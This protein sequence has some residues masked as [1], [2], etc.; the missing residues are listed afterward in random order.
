MM[1]NV[2]RVRGTLIVLGQSMPAAEVRHSGECREHRSPPLSALRG[3][4]VSVWVSDRLG[5]VAYLLAGV[6][7]AM[8][9]YLLWCHPPSQRLADVTEDGTAHFLVVRFQHVVTGPSRPTQSN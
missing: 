1:D 5:P 9:R 7:A 4:S 6:Y 8:H 2:V 3:R